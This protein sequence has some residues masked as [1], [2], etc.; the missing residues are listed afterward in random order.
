VGKPFKRLARVISLA[1]ILVLPLTVGSSSGVPAD[2][3][4]VAPN[5]VNMLDCNGHSATYQSVRPGMRVMCADPFFRENGVAER[6]YDNGNY[7]GHDEPTVK[8]ISGAPG[9]GSHMTYLMQLAVDPKAKPTPSG[10]VTHYAELSPAPW[11]G[12]PICDPR[13]YPQNPCTPNNDQNTGL[14]AR[15]DAGSAFEELQFY[16]PGFGPFQDGPSCDPTFYCAALNIDSLSCT[17]GFARCNNNCFEPINFAYLQTD[18]EPAG[19]PSPQLTNSTTFLANS[20]TL[21]MRQGDKLRV[22]LQD[23][24]HGLKTTVQDLTSG[25]TGFMVAS[26]A[27]GFM[28]TDAATCNGFPFD[29]HP[30]YNTASKQNQ[31]PWAALEGGV[32][33]EQEI[34]HF[35][36]CKS[37][38]DP[39]PS[40]LIPFDPAASWTCVGG[41]EPTATGEGPCT[42]TTAGLA[43]ANSKTEGGVACTASTTNCELSDATCIPSGPRTIT[44]AGL[45]PQTWSWPVAGCLQNVTQN[46]D[47]DFDGNS[48]LADWPNGDSN[49]PTSFKYAG[50]F[51]AHGKPYPQIQI[52]TDLPAS[53]NDCN[54]VTGVGCSTLP[55]GAKF[56][57]YWTLGVQPGFSGNASAC[58]WNFGNTIEDVTTNNLGKL[59]QYGTPDVARFAGTTI[60]AV[61][62]NPQLDK[63]CGQDHQD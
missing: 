13:S 20:H 33:M 53:E 52:Q 62:A 57:P 23:T 32:L 7:I 15:T 16:A 17:F 1:S 4:G 42:I 51:D 18:G 46:G 36:S 59:A 6:A 34:G 19:P 45:A 43:C 49:H 56:Y 55:H 27:N 37:V 3:G 40:F 47:V 39:L 24:K 25:K 58:L 21:K 41:V 10:S 5:P 63:T 61:M 12:L 8:F 9:S 44:F 60:S 22:T 28:N 30:E 14:G 38:K 48:Y 31:V 11:F 29:F 54:V 26:A 2:T 50:P 35:E